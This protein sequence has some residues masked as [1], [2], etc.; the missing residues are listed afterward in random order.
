[1]VLRQVVT[2]AWSYTLYETDGQYVLSVLCGSAAMYELNIPLEPDDVARVTSD[3]A[4][5]DSLATEIRD[6]P[7]RFAARSIK[8]C[9]ETERKTG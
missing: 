8:I 5:L 7:H 4:F 2:K 6:N 1:M 9:V 3:G